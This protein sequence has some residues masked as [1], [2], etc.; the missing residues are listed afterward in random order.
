MFYFYS[1]ASDN[2]DKAFEIG[3]CP[4]KVKYLVPTLDEATY[5]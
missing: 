5:V 1:S 3:Y 4:C 2:I